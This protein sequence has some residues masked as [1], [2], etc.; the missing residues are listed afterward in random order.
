MADRDAAESHALILRLLLQLRKDYLSLRRSIFLY[1]TEQGSWGTTVLFVLHSEIKRSGLNCGSFVRD[2]TLWGSCLENDKHAFPMFLIVISA[3]SHLQASTSS[4]LFLPLIQSIP[5]DEKQHRFKSRNWEII[6]RRDELAAADGP[7]RMCRSE[8]AVSSLEEQRRWPEDQSEGCRG[9]AG[10]SVSQLP[11]G[12]ERGLRAPS[13]RLGPEIQNRGG[14][15]TSSNKL[16]S[17]DRPEA[18]WCCCCACLF[19]REMGTLKQLRK[20]FTIAVIRFNVQLGNYLF[21]DIFKSKFVTQWLLGTRLKVIFWSAWIV[22]RSLSQ[23][24]AFNHY[25]EYK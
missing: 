23:T 4:I 21:L 1:G 6:G 7:G 14:I 12:T 18:S 20:Q 13:C 24:I 3:R 15:H 19:E 9:L 5:G 8:V 17:A 22:F 10:D 16:H 25:P 11:P 2:A